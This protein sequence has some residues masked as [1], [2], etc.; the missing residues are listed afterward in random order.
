VSVS[1]GL[2]PPLIVLRRCIY[3]VLD[4]RICGE[5]FWNDAYLCNPESTLA[6]EE[7]DAFAANIDARRFVKQRMRRGVLLNLAIVEDSIKVSSCNG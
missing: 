6:N 4:L 1:L 7:V 5:F 3:F 2:S